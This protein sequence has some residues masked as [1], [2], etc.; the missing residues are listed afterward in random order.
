MREQRL[1]QLLDEIDERYITESPPPE[2]IRRPRL[3]AWAACLCMTLL[4]VALLF[5]TATAVSA[6]FREAV[7]TLLFPVYAEDTP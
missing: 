6:D 4:T 3:P 7:G 1:L 5:G 2:V